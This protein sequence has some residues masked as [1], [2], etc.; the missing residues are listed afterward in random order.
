MGVST[1]NVSD[2]FV[3]VWMSGSVLLLNQKQLRKS[4]MLKS[5]MRVEGKCFLNLSDDLWLST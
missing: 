2:W 3:K 1:L 4:K 5:E